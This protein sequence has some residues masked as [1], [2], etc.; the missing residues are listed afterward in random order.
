MNYSTA[1]NVVNGY[2]SGRIGVLIYRNILKPPIMNMLNISDLHSPDKNL[3]F[4]YKLLKELKLDKWTELDQIS[5][6]IAHF[7]K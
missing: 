2:V 5:D 3:K 6:I 7:K 4:C 1:K